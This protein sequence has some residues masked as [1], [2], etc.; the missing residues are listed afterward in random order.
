[1]LKLAKLFFKISCLNVYN[2]AGKLRAR[3]EDEKGHRKNA[4][5]MIQ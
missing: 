5:V 2:N 3:E 1:M 4:K